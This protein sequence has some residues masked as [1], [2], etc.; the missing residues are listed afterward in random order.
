MSPEC[1]GRSHWCHSSHPQ[2]ALGPV[3]EDDYMNVSRLRETVL[4]CGERVM[5]HVAWMG[6]DSQRMIGKFET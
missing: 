5:G 3:G 6:R 1:R 2:R 4:G